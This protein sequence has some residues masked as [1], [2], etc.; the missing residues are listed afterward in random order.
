MGHGMAASGPA[1]VAC[2]IQAMATLIGCVATSLIQESGGAARTVQEIPEIEG[3]ERDHGGDGDDEHGR[4]GAP[5]AP[6]GPN[7]RQR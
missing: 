1:G 6:V 2:A 5:G 7:F 3:H 4:E